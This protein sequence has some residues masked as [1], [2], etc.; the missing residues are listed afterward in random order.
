MSYWKVLLEKWK[1]FICNKRRKRKNGLFYIGGSDTLPPPL[2][3]DVG[4]SE[5][6]RR[7]A[8]KTG[9]SQK[10]LIQTLLIS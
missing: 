1:A 9:L 10:I 3:A 2:S 4:Q 7:K 5:V 6:V 8:L